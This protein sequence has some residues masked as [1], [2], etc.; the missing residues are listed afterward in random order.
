MCCNARVVEKVKMKMRVSAMCTFLAAL[1]VA[2]QA[3]ARAADTPAIPFI[4]LAEPQ[5]PS[6]AA[7]KHV[8][9]TAV[10]LA[11][12]GADSVPGAAKLIIS[13]GDD[14]LDQAALAAAQ[15]S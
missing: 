5:F 10:V 7:S 15:Q 1:V 14:R 9:G 4:N 11:T 3:A 12:V 8:E 6:V 13:S 2:T